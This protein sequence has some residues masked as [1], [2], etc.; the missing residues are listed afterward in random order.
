[1]EIEKI[2]GLPA[3]PLFVHMPVV[4]IPLAG[5]IAIVFAVKPKWLDRFGWG[6]VALSGVGMIGGILA[7]SSGEGLEEMMRANGE[8][9]SSSLNEHAELG[10]TARSVSIL[11]FMVV[12]AIVV[13][14]YLVK[15]G[16]AQ[17]NSLGRIAASKAG[18]I[19]MA[20]VLAISA[21]GATATVIA[22]GHDGAK[23]VWHEEFAED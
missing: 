20:V 15:K 4:L 21:V 16:F 23:Q 8:Q 18:A 11:F 7:A 9:I 3:H 10:E 12:L 5:V 1:M 13:I 14:R 17:T 2:S 6:L 19:V 22:A